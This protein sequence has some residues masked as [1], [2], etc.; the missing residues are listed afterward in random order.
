MT[1]AEAVAALEAISGGEPEAD[2]GDAD[3]ILLAVVPPEVAAAYRALMD[4]SPWWATA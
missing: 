1:K 4:R 2:H 3:G